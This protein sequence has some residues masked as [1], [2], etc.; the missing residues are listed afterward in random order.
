[1][2]KNGCSDVECKGIAEESAEEPCE[3]TEYELHLSL[4]IKELFKVMDDLLFQKKLFIVYI[5]AWV[6][7]TIISIWPHETRKE[8]D[9]VVEFVNRVIELIEDER[10]FQSKAENLDDLLEKVKIIYHSINRKSNN[11]LGAYDITTLLE[12]AYT[13]CLNVKQE[14]LKPKSKCDVLFLLVQKSKEVDPLYGLSFEQRLIFENLEKDLAEC[15]CEAVKGYVS[16]LKE[17]IRAQNKSIEQVQTQKLINWLTL[18]SSIVSILG[19]VPIIL[20][21]LS[22]LYKKFVRPTD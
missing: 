9:F 5:I 16:Q 11:K 22:W 1:M 8:E 18:V 7:L 12:D 4:H 3:P 14:N 17:I 21:A 13:K 10:D 15:G 2:S 6:L 19:L 20:A